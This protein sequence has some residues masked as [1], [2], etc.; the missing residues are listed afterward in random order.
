MDIA[1][2]FANNAGVHYSIRTLAK[3]HSMSRRKALRHVISLMNSG[4]V[5]HSKP[6]NVGSTKYRLPLF[7]KA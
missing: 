4:L 6:H 7:S 1:D 2:T 3:R 5:S